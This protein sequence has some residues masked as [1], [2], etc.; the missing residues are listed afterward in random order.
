MLVKTDSCS[1]R[2][3]RLLLATQLAREVLL[4]ARVLLGAQLGRG[5]AR[6]VAPRALR[7]PGV[8]LGVLLGAWGV[9]RRAGDRQLLLA[10]EPRRAR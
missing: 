1:A 8:L 3:H 6:G 5:A 9:A 10:A 2:D 7:G 4:G